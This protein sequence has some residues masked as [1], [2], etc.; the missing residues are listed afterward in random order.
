MPTLEAAFRNLFCNQRVDAEER[1][2]PG[3]EWDA[4]PR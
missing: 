1:W 3:A 2:I 4:V